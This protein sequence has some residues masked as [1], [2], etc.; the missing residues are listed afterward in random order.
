MWQYYYYY[1]YHY[2]TNKRILCFWGGFVSRA[3]QKPKSW[4][5]VQ[6]AVKKHDSGEVF[7][8]N[9]KFL[10]KKQFHEKCL[11]SL[12][13]DS[14]VF[15]WNIWWF[16]SLGELKKILHNPISSINMIQYDM[17]WYGT[18]WYDMISHWFT[19]VKTIRLLSL[20]WNEYAPC[21]A[22]Y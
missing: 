22:K 6:L 2:Y 4:G 19:I 17:I 18:I 16:T 5:S 15:L 3:S 14:R 20:S 10:G 21:L 7:Y 12:N 9:W 1:Y 8:E 13:L 11:I